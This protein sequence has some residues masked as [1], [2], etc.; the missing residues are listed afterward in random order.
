MSGPHQPPPFTHRPLE[1]DAGAEG[2]APRPTSQT[3]CRHRAARRTPEDDL[4]IPAP[5]SMLACVDAELD[6]RRLAGIHRWLWIAGRP[7]PP[8]PL[9]QQRLLSRDLVITERLDQHL[10]WGNGRMLLKP[11]PALPPGA[12]LLGRA[13]A[14]RPA[15]LS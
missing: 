1:D 6:P 11:L 10:V 15:A 8:R 2:V 5:Q 3:C 14:L 12:A 4:T 9:R 7:M 13:P